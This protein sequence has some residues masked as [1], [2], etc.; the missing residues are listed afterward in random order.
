[1]TMDAMALFGWFAAMKPKEEKAVPEPEFRPF[2]FPR[3]EG[4]VRAEALRPANT[5]RAPRT[6]KELGVPGPLAKELELALRLMGNAPG[7]NVAGLTFRTPDGSAYAVKLEA[8][9]VRAASDRAA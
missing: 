5:A 6:L 1:M 4:A 8:A 3:E 9:P 2:R 7:E